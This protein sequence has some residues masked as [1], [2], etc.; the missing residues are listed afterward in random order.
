[1]ESTMCGVQNRPVD[2]RPLQDQVAKAANQC[3][4]NEVQ[5][6]KDRVSTLERQMED[7]YSRLGNNQSALANNACQCPAAGCLPPPNVDLA[8]APAGKGLTTDPTGWPKGSVQTAGGYT[9]V[10]EGKDAAWSI[11]GPN[12]S[13]GDKPLSRIWGD[14]HVDEAD[15]QRWDFT[16][17]SNFRLPDGTMI[18]VKTTSETGQSVTQ[19]LNIVNGSD[20]VSIDGINNN[21]PTTSAVSRDGFEYRNQLIQQNPNRDTFVMGGTGNTKDG[22]DR[23]QWARERNGQIDGVIGGTISN[24]DGKGSYGQQID[25]NRK[26]TIDPS[27]RPDPRTNPEAWGNQ[28]RGEVVD[29]AARS[30]P[31]ELADFVT[32]SVKLDDSVQRFV[33]DIGKALKSVFGDFGFGGCLD[34]FG[35]DVAQPFKHAE[36]CFEQMSRQWELQALLNSSRSMSRQMFC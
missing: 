32:S 35:A 24:V 26:F 6:L 27:L 23:V 30:L 33:G 13:P 10:P 11:F 4:T 3:P 36:N 31:K 12:Q 1:M 15:G 16:K 18:D 29:A 22:N 9:I 2:V 25:Q 14:P 17:S 5:Q 34:L 20:H 21:R 8:G 28:L 19:G 7:V